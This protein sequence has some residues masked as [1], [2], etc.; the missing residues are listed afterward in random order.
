MENSSLKLAR[1]FVRL[2]FGLAFQLCRFAL[3]LTGKFLCLSFSLIGFIT[4][5]LLSLMGS[6]FCYV[7]AFELNDKKFSVLDMVECTEGIHT[8]S[9]NTLHSNIGYRTIHL[10]QSILGS[11]NG[12]FLMADGDGEASRCSHRADWGGDSKSCSRSSTSEERH[13]DYCLYFRHLKLSKGTII[14]PGKRP[15]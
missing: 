15:P 11:F 5:S 13:D 1:N 6:F 8:A 3:G 7:L 12:T 4:G 10:L 9:L 14:S 2:S